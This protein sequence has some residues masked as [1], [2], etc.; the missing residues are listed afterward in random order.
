MV[1]LRMGKKQTVG[2]KWEVLNKIVPKCNKKYDVA[3]AYNDYLPLYYLV[4]YVEADKKIAWNHIDYIEAKLDASYDRKYYEKIDK[5]ITISES[6]A[7]K[8]KITF[9]EYKDKNKCSRKY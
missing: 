3:I 7:E 9:P 2:E 5:L 6:C 4:E 1:T 8:L